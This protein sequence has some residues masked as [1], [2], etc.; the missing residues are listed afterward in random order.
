MAPSYMTEVKLV[1]EAAVSHGTLEDA[2]VAV[3]E[4]WS[5]RCH[6]KEYHEHQELKR[7]QLKPVV[8]QVIEAF[9]IED[10]RGGY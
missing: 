10:P 6:N 2:M 8:N 3:A 4:W 7:T 9:S 1:V 5:Q